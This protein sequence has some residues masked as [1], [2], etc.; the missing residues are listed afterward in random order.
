VSDKIKPS[1]R[2]DSKVNL[3]T[4]IN[5]TEL[6]YFKY[7]TDYGLCVYARK[8]ISAGTVLRL[9]GYLGRAVSPDKSNLSERPHSIYKSICTFLYNEGE[10]NEYK[11]SHILLGSAAVLNYACANHANVVPNY[12]STTDKEYWELVIAVK[13]IPKD[14]QLLVNYSTAD[15]ALCSFTGRHRA[16]YGATDFLRF[17]TIVAEASRKAVSQE[18]RARRAAKR[19]FHEV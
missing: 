11:R 1:W 15:T 9:R 2:V 10:E 16:Y 8:M 4:C 12:A 17:D 14:D 7:T 13:N 19:P 3:L 5:I 6:Y 18:N